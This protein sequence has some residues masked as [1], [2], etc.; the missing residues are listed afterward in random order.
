MTS[1]P[2]GVTIGL[3]V[4]DDAPC[5]ARLSRDVIEHGLPWSYRPERVRRMLR[6]PDNVAAVARDGATLAGFALIE[7]GEEAAHLVLLAVQPAWQGRGVGQ[8]LL[9]WVLACARTAGVAVVR[10]ETRAANQRAIDLYRRAS[11][12][13]TTRIAGYYSGREDAQRLVLVLRDPGVTLP[14]P[15]MPSAARR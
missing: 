1:L 6:H 7:V 15:W 4:E 13:P 9:H 2:P 10:V 14:A 8:A 12:V 3:P 11:F 5:I